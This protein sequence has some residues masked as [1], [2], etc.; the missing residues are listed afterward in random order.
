MVAPRRFWHRSYYSVHIAEQGM[1]V[2]A[3]NSLYLHI[4]HAKTQMPCQYQSA[5]VNI[6]GL[7]ILD[8]E[9]FPG[10]GSTAVWQS[11][12]HQS[13]VHSDASRLTCLSQKS[14]YMFN[15]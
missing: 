6:H 11:H 3:S 4:W 14:P 7:D 2:H 8:A 1:L 10:I 13:H 12:M 5:Y 15:G 9:H